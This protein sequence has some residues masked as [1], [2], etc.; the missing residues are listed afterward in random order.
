MVLSCLRVFVGFRV[1]LHTMGVIVDRLILPYLILARALLSGTP[2][3]ICH[4]HN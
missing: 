2:V 4:N 3:K 1:E